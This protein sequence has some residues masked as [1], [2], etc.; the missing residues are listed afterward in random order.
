VGRGQSEQRALVISS[1]PANATEA[2][3]LLLACCHELEPA[4]RFLCE[5]MGERTGDSVGICNAF[6]QIVLPLLLYAL[7]RHMKA[8]TELEGVGRG[9]GYRA[10]L[11]G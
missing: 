8:N 10:Q 1:P 2:L 5:W 3:D 6:G 7:G 11:T 9:S 4:W